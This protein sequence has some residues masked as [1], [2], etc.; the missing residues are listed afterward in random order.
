MTMNARHLRIYASMSCAPP[1]I[2]VQPDG[3]REFA[4]RIEDRETLLRPFEQQTQEEPRVAPF[5]LENAANPNG[6]QGAEDP[7]MGNWST[8]IC[9]CLVNIYP[10][11]ILSIFAPGLVLNYVL[12]AVFDDPEKAKVISGSYNV[13]LLSAL[14]CMLV[15]IFQRDEGLPVIVILAIYVVAVAILMRTRQL[16]RA[17]YG[18]PGSFLEDGCLSFWCYPCVVSQLARHVLRFANLGAGSAVTPLQDQAENV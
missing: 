7:S 5:M 12:R 14:V 15:F 6:A 8:G 18:I 1:V 3:S 13:M 16:M 17:M 11:C 2:V 10:T 4:N 9:S